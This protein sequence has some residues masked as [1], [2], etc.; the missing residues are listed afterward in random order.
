MKTY[1]DLKESLDKLPDN[2]LDKP[3]QFYF[4]DAGEMLSENLCPYLFSESPSDSEFAEE[5]KEDY[6]NISPCC[7]IMALH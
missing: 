3:L 2:E 6:P 4:E 1:R 7:F 5:M